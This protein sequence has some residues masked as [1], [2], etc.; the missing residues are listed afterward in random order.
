MATWR[1]KCFLP[2]QRFCISIFTLSVENNISNYHEGSVGG[3]RFLKT[4]SA[5]YKVLKKYLTTHWEKKRTRKTIPTFKITFQ[6]PSSF[7]YYHTVKSWHYWSKQQ[8]G[9]LVNVRG[10][11]ACYRHFGSQGQTSGSNHIPFW[12]WAHVI[13]SVWFSLT[14]R[15]FFYLL[16]VLSG[17]RFFRKRGPGTSQVKTSSENY[18]IV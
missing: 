16:K 15:D 6:L 7:L 17:P 10:V 13:H 8:V 9:G 18:E 2:V 1:Q 5:Y 14:K 12:L 3:L 11:V 4:Y